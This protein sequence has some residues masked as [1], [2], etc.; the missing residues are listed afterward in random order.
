MYEE[1]RYKEEKSKPVEEIHHMLPIKTKQGLQQ[2]S[3]VI[4]KVLLVIIVLDIKLYR[5]GGYWLS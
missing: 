5:G 1:K 3:R 4:E 2:R